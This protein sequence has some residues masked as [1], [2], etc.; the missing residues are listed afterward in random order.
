MANIL[1]ASLGESPIVVTAM[2]NLL[3]T[4]EKQRKLGEIDKVVVLYPEKEDMIQL[5]Y[6]LIEDALRGKCKL[7]PWMLPFEDANGE[8]ESYTFLRLLFQLLFIHQESG[9]NV[10]LSLAG[11]RK[12]MS[13]LMA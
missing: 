1:I 2:Y 11:G 10:Y 12:N 13:A 3:T 6:D 8:E 4:E 5:G 9:N 7:E